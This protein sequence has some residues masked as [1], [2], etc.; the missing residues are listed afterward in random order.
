M[1]W[2]TG[3]ATGPSPVKSPNQAACIW[4]ATPFLAHNENAEPQG[5]SFTK[6]SNVDDDPDSKN[7]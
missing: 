2:V 4:P 3:R 5:W 6:F 1:R 7:V